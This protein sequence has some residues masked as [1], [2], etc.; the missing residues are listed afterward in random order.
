MRS[1]F[2]EAVAESG[3]SI[4]KKKSRNK[5]IDSNDYVECQFLLSLKPT[6]GIYIILFI[7]AQ[8]SCL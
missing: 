5:S 4:Q 2:I 8:F 6:K 1:Y 7:L 3:L